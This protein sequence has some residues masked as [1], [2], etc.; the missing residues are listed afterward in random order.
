MGVGG[1][2]SGGGCGSGRLGSLLLFLSL[3][4]GSWLG[5][6]L[7]LRVVVVVLLGWK[8]VVDLSCGV[9]LWI[10]DAGGLVQGGFFSVSLGGPFACFFP[11]RY[12]VVG[13][14]WT[15]LWQEGGSWLLRLKSEMSQVI[16]VI[17]TFGTT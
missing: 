14:S 12:L 9:F 3:W 13:R 7:L 10:W 16:N 4:L 6:L 17:C 2:G 5:G 8:H 15:S 1:S 11:M